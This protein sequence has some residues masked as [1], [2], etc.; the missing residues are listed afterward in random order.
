MAAYADG[1]NRMLARKRFCFRAF[2]DIV[3][4]CVVSGPI[5]LISVAAEPIHRGFF[6]DDRSLKHPYR[7][8]TVP[9]WILALVSMGLPIICILLVECLL[10]R[11]TRCCVLVPTEIPL[12]PRSC[13]ESSYCMVI[14]FF[15]GAAVTQLLTEVGKFSVGGLR[16][17][18]LV[19]CRPENIPANCSGV[20]ITENVC[21]GH[22]Y[23]MMKEARLSF[24]SGHASMSMFSAAFL[25][26]YLQNRLVCGQAKLLRPVLQVAVFCMAFYT[27]LSRVSDYKH[28]WSDVLGGALLGLIICYLIMVC[29]GDYHHL[30]VRRAGPGAGGSVGG[31]RGSSRKERLP[32]YRQD[33]S[34]TSSDG[35]PD[36][37]P[38][39]DTIQ[40]LVENQKL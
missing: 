30:T 18:F 12:V 3:C 27:C 38:T 17:H 35:L 23:T 11:T 7:E 36:D 21:T 13:V 1:P 28:H 22:N 40:V 39:Q 24:P 2:V 29:L 10:Q 16:P 6:C 26:F 34:S 14:T 4:L 8:D 5:L 25:M 33:N 32:M 20:F 37:C 15:F 19:V 31:S 9:T